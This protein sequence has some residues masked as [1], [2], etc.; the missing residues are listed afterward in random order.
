MK[1]IFVSSTFN[2]MQYERDRIQHRVLPELQDFA[3]K[4]GRTVDF[5]DLRWGVNTSGLEEGETGR[6][7]LSV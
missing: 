1:S 6:K 4:Y 7:V 3:G 5:I 2:D